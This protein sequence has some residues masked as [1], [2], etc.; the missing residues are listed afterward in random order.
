V[1]QEEEEEESAM[2]VD[3]VWCVCQARKPSQEKPKFCFFLFG[4]EGR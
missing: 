4:I 3:S 2:S 1:Q